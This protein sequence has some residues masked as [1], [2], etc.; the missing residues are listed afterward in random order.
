[1]YSGS[2][3][4]NGSLGGPE[5]PVTCSGSSAAIR[6]SADASAIRSAPRAAE[7][8]V[9]AGD[10]PFEVTTTGYPRAR[11]AKLR[12]GKGE[13]RAGGGGDGGDRR[14]VQR[15]VTGT[16]SPPGPRTTTVPLIPPP[17]AGRRRGPDAGVGGEAHA[18]QPQARALGAHLPAAQAAA[19]AVDDGVPDGFGGHR[20][21][22]PHRTPGSA[23]EATSAGR[24]AASVDG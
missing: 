9:D 21:R 12:R 7:N 20:D 2:V 6:S 13:G 4:S 17:R 10:R 3:A 23:P 8:T 15:S 11:V 5:A 18:A 24:A 16:P 14:S 1:M 22:L 19:H